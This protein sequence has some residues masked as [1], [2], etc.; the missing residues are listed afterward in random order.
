[1]A[2]PTTVTNQAKMANVAKICHGFGEYSNF[3]PKGVLWRV[4]ILTKIANMTK[5]LQTFKQYRES[6]ESGKKSPKGKRKFKLDYSSN[7]SANLTP[8]GAFPC[9]PYAFPL[10]KCIWSNQ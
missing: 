8:F 4:E 3:M 2:N 10:L 5:I 7:A 6:T 9:L 1:M